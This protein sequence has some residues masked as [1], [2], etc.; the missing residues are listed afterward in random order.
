MST[1]LEISALNLNLGVPGIDKLQSSNANNTAS[2][3]G[4]A[5]FA[6]VLKDTG[7]NVVN[8]LQKAEASSIA[9]IKGDAGPY[10]V[11]SA[12][13]A[14]EQ[15]LRMTIAIREKAIESYKE[16]TRMQI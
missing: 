14:A 3:V 4:Q 10:Q 12:V 11:A 9:G 13:M 1:G 5:S 16:I 8:S 2:T 15:N 6:E 7:L